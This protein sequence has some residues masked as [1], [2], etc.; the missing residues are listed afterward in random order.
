MDGDDFDKG[1]ELLLPVGSPN[2]WRTVSWGWFD[3]IRNWMESFSIPFSLLFPRLCQTSKSSS[4]ESSIDTDSLHVLPLYGHET[5]S[6][7]SDLSYRTALLTL[8][9]QL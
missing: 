3:I 5:S 4:I 9:I 2:D 6:H 1:L 7:I 8:N